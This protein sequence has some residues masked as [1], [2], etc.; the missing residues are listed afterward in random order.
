MSEIQ[1]IGHSLFVHMKRVYPSV[2]VRQQLGDHV[3]S[4][5]AAKV[6]KKRACVSQDSCIAHQEDPIPFFSFVCDVKMSRLS[7]AYLD[8]M[9]LL[10]VQMC[11]KMTCSTSIDM[12]YSFE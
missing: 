4:V 9:S 10:G 8:I 3:V 2:R 11:K 1:K 7:L 5:C 6:H 12:Q